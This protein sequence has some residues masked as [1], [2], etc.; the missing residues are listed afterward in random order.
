MAVRRREAEVQK[1]E[2]EE[3]GRRREEERREVVGSGGAEL[4]ALFARGSTG[5]PRRD[6]ETGRLLDCGLS[7]TDITQHAASRGWAFTEHPT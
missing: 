6:P 2:L 7:S 3:W 4:A 1:G 5:R